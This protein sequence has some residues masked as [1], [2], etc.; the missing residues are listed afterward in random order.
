[1]S[2]AR[3][4]TKVT[5]GT[6]GRAIRS[7]LGRGVSVRSGILLT[8]ARR[9]GTSKKWLVHKTETSVER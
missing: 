8:A 3:T 9:K 1:M 2:M 4:S 7:I 5:G 6:G